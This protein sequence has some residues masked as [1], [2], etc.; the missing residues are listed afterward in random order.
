MSK[1]DEE[2]KNGKEELIDIVSLCSDYF[3]VFRKMWIQVAALMLIG[4]L[5]CYFRGVTSYQP[6]YTASATFTINIREEQQDGISSNSSFFDNSAAEQMAKTFPYILTS[7]VLQRRVAKDMGV[8]AVAGSIQASVIEGTN[9]LTISVHDVDA[10]RAYQTLQS[11][12]ENYPE[13]SEVIV[14]KIN[15]EMLD[16]TGI[17]TYPD[18]P[19][20]L[21]RPVIKGA[22]AGLLLG[23]VWA[24]LV[25]I[26]RKTVR[27]EEDCPKL[28]NRR[29]LGGVP[30]VRFKERSRKIEHHLNILDENIDPDFAEAFR[31]IRNKVEY[32]ARENNLKCIMI[33]SALAGEGKSTIAVNLA[34]S[35][36]QNG[37]KVALVDCDLR[38][39]S[40]NEILNVTSKKGLAE[41]LKGEA[42]FSECVISGKEMNLGE[43]MKF[44]YV[45]GGKAVADASNLLSNLKISGIVNNLK[46][47]A[48]YVILD[49]APAGLLTDAGI[50]AQFAD[51]AVFIIKKDFA[52]VDH[53]LEG[54]EHLAES[55]VHMI[56]CVLNGTEP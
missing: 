12:I 47:Q 26:S 48:D 31:I 30:Q 5:L 29:C 8:P 44:L 49:S 54:M 25:M 11:V 52:K 23:L 3:R 4:A 1:Q 14:G 37:K 41:Y 13:I 15:M 27:R 10:E 21:K 16:E 35:L 33:T 56:G 51:G 34:L 28:V 9:L 38:H 50:L 40:D 42:R 39:P 2:Q 32:S 18:N 36:A 46:R 7:G 22:M 53:I 20:D 43:S 6:Y 19:R 55:K 17:P 45:P 24:G